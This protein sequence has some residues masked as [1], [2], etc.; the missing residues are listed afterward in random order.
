MKTNTAWLVIGALFLTGCIVREVHEIRYVRDQG[1]RAPGDVAAGG[2]GAACDGC[3]AESTPGVIVA[4]TQPPA[5]L[6]EEGLDQPGPGYVW[7]A[8]YWNWNGFEWVWIPGTWVA[9]ADGMVFVPP[10][11]YATGLHCLYVPGRWQR[12]NPVPPVVGGGRR[13]PPLRDYRTAGKKP[14]KQPPVRDH[15]GET[16][17]PDPGKVIVDRD[18]VDHDLVI[19]MPGRSRPAG[20]GATLPGGVPPRVRADAGLA[21]QPP[22]VSGVIGA[23]TA[24]NE[25]DVLLTEPRPVRSSP[26]APSAD[27]GPP[28]AQPGVVQPG[29]PPRVPPAGRAPAAGWARPAPPT[30]GTSQ[31]GLGASPAVRVAPPFRVAPSPAGGAGSPPA[32]GAPPPPA[33]AP[34]PISRPA[35][36][37]QVAPS[38]PASSGANP[39]RPAPAVRPSAPARAAP[40][41][42]AR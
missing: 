29:I 20:H 40:R 22:S 11:Y 17:Q 7:V 42:H 15:R 12:G 25:P 2:D 35:P 5:P 9:P 24:G 38:A 26:L 21:P 31:P 19:R 32:G 23:G 18:L 34:P 1:G 10:A 36:P 6:E 27:S 3:D 39:A 41:G 16:P 30:W 28:T 14:G 4:E 33:G 8:G 37:M 13:S